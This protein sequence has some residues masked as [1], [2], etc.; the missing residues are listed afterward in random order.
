MSGTGTSTTG[1]HVGPPPG[2]GGHRWTRTIAAVVGAVVAIIGLLYGG[3]K[4]YK[5]K[6]E[7]IDRRKEVAGLYKQL[8]EK[9]AKIADLK[10]KLT[11]CREVQ[12]PECPPQKECEACPDVPE[13]P[14]AATATVNTRALAQQLAPLLPAPS[15]PPPR[16]SVCPTP[17]CPKAQIFLKLPPELTRMFGGQDT[18]DVTPKPK[19][20]K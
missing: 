6:M 13:C 3:H 20:S 1:T 18:I 5:W 12:A 16:G 11:A 17:V 10:Q 14:K 2:T 9:D 4:A 8:G 15:C 19:A 7:T